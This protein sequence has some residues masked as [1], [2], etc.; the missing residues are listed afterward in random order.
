MKTRYRL[1]VPD[2]GGAPARYQAGFTLT[3]LAVVLIIVALLIGGLLMPLSEQDNQRR[4]S[5]TRKT[6]A[7][8]NDALL[9]FAA[10]NGRLP[11]PAAPAATG[12]EAPLGG[13][14]CTNPYDGLVPGVTL[15]LGSLHGDGY[16]LDAWGNPIHLAVSRDP[17]DGSATPPFWNNSFTTT[18]TAA[19][20]IAGIG[21]SNLHPDLQ[22]CS[23]GAPSASVQCTGNALATNAVAV[24]YSLGRN[25]T[26][27]GTGTDEQQNP[28]PHVA[29]P[30]DRLF[31]SREA[32]DAGSANGEFDDIVIWLSPNILYNKMIAAGRLP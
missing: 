23:G 19:A 22:V 21:M 20:G 28:N 18:P 4:T 24:I 30:A 26:I 7:D 5:E 16:V 29:A 31:V 25:G 9:G 6:L 10:A 8:I 1:S 13:G 32:A 3:E 2:A 27:G 11:C 17:S 12:V 14:V 15:G